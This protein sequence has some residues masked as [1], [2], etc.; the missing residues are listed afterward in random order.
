MIIVV[1]SACSGAEGSDPNNPGA[2]RDG[3][4]DSELNDGEV[5]DSI[6][7]DT[8][9]SKDAGRDTEIGTP[10]CDPNIGWTAPLSVCSQA[11]PCINPLPLYSEDVLSEPTAVPETCDTGAFGIYH[12]RPTY[13][14]DALQTRV[15]A[16]GVTR[17]YCEYRPVGTSSAAP[18]PLLLFVH[19]SGSNARAVYD[20]TML[21]DKATSFDMSGS[22]SNPG[23]ILVAVQGRNL[24]WL[25]ADP[26]DGSK[27][28]TFHRDLD[29]PSDNRDVALYDAVIDSLVTDGVVDPRRIYVMG[30][31]NGARFAAMYGIGR[32]TTPT[33]AGNRVAAVANYSGGDPFE[34]T[35]AFQEPSCKLAHYPRASIPFMIISRVCDI[36]ACDAE[37][38]V[39][40]GGVPPGNIAA[41]WVNALES[42][43]GADPVEWRIIG[44]LAGPRTD[45]ALSC[46]LSRALVNHAR[47]PDGI[48]D[49]SDADLEPEMLGFLR[50]HPL[51]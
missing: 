37:Q 7:G 3:S 13:G 35:N 36:I 32:Y 24:H 22:G 31:S 21:R 42:Q 51:P 2:N 29:A 16:D 15:D 6:D 39:A 25:T 8:D 18:R 45:C 30:W 50:D 17:Y 9:E 47:W 44:D 28:D 12:G 49:G 11:N 23:F 26:Q 41:D 4:D 14:G 48:Q 34:N 43:V 19:P 1:T 10:A 40:I 33:T 38:A 27:H 5:P 20:S 46:T